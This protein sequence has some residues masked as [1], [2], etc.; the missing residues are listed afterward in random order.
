[1]KRKIIFYLLCMFCVETI[2]SESLLKIPKAN[3]VSIKTINTVENSEKNAKTY[4]EKDYPRISKKNKIIINC[5]N[6]YDQNENLLISSDK[7][8]INNVQHNTNSNIFLCLKYDDIFKPENK[9]F[10]YLFDFV[11]GVQELIDVDV[12]KYLLSNDGKKI[13]YVTNF[14]YKESSN[15]HFT[16]FVDQK[17]KTKTI[18]YKDY[19]DEICDGLIIKQENEDVSLYICQDAS[20]I[21][22]LFINSN[23]EIINYALSDYDENTGYSYII[24]PDGSIE[25]LNN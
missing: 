14:N 25:Y 11:K 16:L 23:C 2:F 10:L 19:T 20:V 3:K 15:I 22:K 9:N 24:N 13:Y 4:N 17:R 1:M 21:I 8:E 18:N 5:I 12:N 7:M 6:F